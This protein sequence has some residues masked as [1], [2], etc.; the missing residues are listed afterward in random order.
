MSRRASA[1]LRAA[2]AVFLLSAACSGHSAGTTP[3]APD[4][5]PPPP[6]AIPADAR[7][8]VDCLGNDCTP[9]QVCCAMYV[10][11]KRV[12]YC[13]DG[14]NLCSGSVIECDGP[15]DC[16]SG[17]CCVTSTTTISCAPVQDCIGVTICHTDADCGGAHC[18]P[19]PGQVTKACQPACP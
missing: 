4:A 9:S 6:D 2:A 5:T 13:A 16:A 19:T 11:H 17:V 7:L 14:A 1:A 15:E 3:L 12:A 8:G 10:Q 18:C